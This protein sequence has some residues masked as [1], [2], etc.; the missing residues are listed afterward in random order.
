MLPTESVIP[1]L[2]G[3]KIYTYNGGK[4]KELNVQI[5]IRTSTQVEIVSG[6]NVQDTVLVS[7]LLQIKDGSDVEITTIN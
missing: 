5:G 2:N 1:Q 7:G 4:A 3:H 6:L